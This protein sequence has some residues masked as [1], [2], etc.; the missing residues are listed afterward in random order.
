MSLYN[1]LFIIPI[2]RQS[3]E[4]FLIEIKKEFEKVEQNLIEDILSSGIA[5]EELELFKSKDKKEARFKRWLSQKKINWE[6]NQIIGWIELYAHGVIIKAEL[7]F[8]DSKRILKILKNKNIIYRGKIGDVSDITYQNNME[9]RKDIIDFI[10]YLRKGE[11]GY[12]YLKK[13]YIHD[14]LFI[15]SINYID[16]KSL[17]NSLIKK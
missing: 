2:Y 14:K 6:Y 3:K 8:I 10:D 15:N 11:E 17:V 5:S 4:E 13:Y 7:W 12:T 1:T 16:I 9:I